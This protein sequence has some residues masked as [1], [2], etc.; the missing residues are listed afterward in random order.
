MP[1][2][3]GPAIAPT[4]GAPADVFVETGG[5][6]TVE[7][8]IPAPDPDAEFVA[9]TRAP[10]IEVEIG[11]AVSKTPVGFLTTVDVEDWCE[12]VELLAGTAATATASAFD[13]LWSQLADWVSLGADGR[14]KYTWD[15]K[16]YCAWVYVDGV[17]QAPFIF[18]NPVQMGDGRVALPMV[19]PQD[20]FNYRLLGRAEQ[21]DL[22]DD[23]GSFE[24]YA[25]IAAM[26]ADGWVFDDDVTADIVT[27]GVRGTKALEVSGDG[28]VRSPKITLQG[29]DGISVVVDGQVFGKWDDAV[30]SGAL[31]A[32]AKVQR[33]DSLTPTDLEYSVAKGGTRPD[34]SSGW[35]DDPVPFAAR[36]SPQK[37]TNRGWLELRSFA[38]VNSY[39]DLAQLRLS[40]QSGYPAG[41]ER[42]LSLYVGR[43]HTDFVS[44]RLGGWPDGLRVKVKALTGTEASMRW[45]HA[46]RT[47][48]RDVL[49]MVLEADGGPECR[50]TPGWYLEV[51]GR[52]G[53]DRE[54]ISLSD[55]D[56]AAPSWTID[57]GARIDDYIADT[58]RGSG[59][60]FL[61][62]V[63][64]QPDQGNVWRI[65][66]QVQAPTGRSLNDCQSWAEAHARV[67]ARLQVTATVQVPWHVADQI[68][69]GDSLWVTMSDGDQGLNKRMRVLR[70]RWMPKT[71]QCELTLGAA[72]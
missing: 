24:D 49:A 44:R 13:P 12:D 14:L 1:T 63:V 29:S 41:D 43:L 55:H 39:Y 67:A 2:M 66:A 70:M 57:P 32:L 33:T 36:M 60:N 61:A 40:V 64:S 15:P 51:W 16:G 28:W 72:S 25:D 10:V 69:C 38:G 34:D 68:V 20:Q 11:R 27:D 50:I 54:D 26:E 7:Q 22:L 65:T 30:P 48:F 4:F 21:E 47:T 42:D 3:L 46:R 71:L 35:T 19:G 8:P 18:M 58:G 5:M 37:I 23:R 45:A 17:P 53:S 56:I 6:L 62:A 52:L 59:V 9:P 31:V